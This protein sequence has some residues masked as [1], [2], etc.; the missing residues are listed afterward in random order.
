[1]LNELTKKQFKEMKYFKPTTPF[2]D[3]IVVPTDN[4]HDSGYRCMKFVL[5]N[6]IKGEISGVVGGSSDVIHFNGIGGW[7]KRL[8]D[9]PS[10]IPIGYRI[11]CLKK[12][13][14]LRIM[15]GHYLEIDDWFYSDFQFYVGKSV[16]DREDL[17]EE[18][19]R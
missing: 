5:W 18:D 15:T 3:I 9:N 8:Y 13:G 19:D 14:Y 2:T 12:S 4:T 10:L 16:Y 1:M 7:G 6:E 11:D 17:G